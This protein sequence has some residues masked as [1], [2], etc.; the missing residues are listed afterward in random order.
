MRRLGG[1]RIQ[2]EELDGGWQFRSLLLSS[3]AW[4]SLL[5]FWYFASSY[6]RPR[7]C[8]LLA[9]LPPGIIR[10]LR[11]WGAYFTSQESEYMLSDVDVCTSEM[12]GQN[13]S[14]SQIVLEN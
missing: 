6:V 9:Q 12:T 10:P 3:K 8:S 5:A 7:H 13:M 11:L 1:C 2:P 4:L 14:E